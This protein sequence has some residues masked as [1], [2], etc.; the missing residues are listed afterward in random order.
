MA[1]T[2]NQLRTLI[3]QGASGVANERELL[4][5]LGFTQRF[6]TPKPGEQARCI[7]WVP[8]WDPNLLL[9]VGRFMLDAETAKLLV[10]QANRGKYAGWALKDILL[11][12]V[13]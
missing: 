6:D 4:T 3:N 5:F 7:G 10:A 11:D 9:L 1:L 13:G 2:R 8:P 12:I